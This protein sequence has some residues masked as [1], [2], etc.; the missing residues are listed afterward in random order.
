MSATNTEVYG[1][2]DVTTVICIPQCRGFPV[3]NG[4]RLLYGCRPA[5][6]VVCI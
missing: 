5:I 2:P 6:T 4:N 1:V 3:V